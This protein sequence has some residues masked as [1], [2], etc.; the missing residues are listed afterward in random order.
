MEYFKKKITCIF[1]ICL[2]A[3]Q[4]NASIAGISESKLDSS[5]ELWSR[6]CGL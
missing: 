1:Y 6:Y 3:K 5:F 2:I 4:S